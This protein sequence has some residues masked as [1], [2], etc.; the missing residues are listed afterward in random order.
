MILMNEGGRL[1]DL[2]PATIGALD[3]VLP[4]CWSH[5]NPVDILGDASG[6]RYGDALAA[7]L[8]DP[9]TDAVLALHCPTALTTP[10]EAARSVAATAKRSRMPLMACWVGASPQ[11]AEARAYWRRKEYPY[12]TRRATR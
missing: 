3:A 1:A 12:T 2:A 4:A 11:V 8:G 5:G 6:Q 7:L 10:M 9:D